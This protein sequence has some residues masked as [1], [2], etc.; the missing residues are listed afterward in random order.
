MGGDSG[1]GSV[2][3]SVVVG[4]GSSVQWMVCCRGS[5]ADQGWLRRS[6]TPG[7]SNARHCPCT[8]TNTG[9]STSGTDI[10]DS[11]GYV[12]GR[13]QGTITSSRGF[14][15]IG[16]QA[17]YG[18]YVS[19]PIKITPASLDS[20]QLQILAVFTWDS[21]D[22]TSPKPC[23]G[24]SAYCRTCPPSTTPPRPFP[25]KSTTREIVPQL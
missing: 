20:F 17:G 15:F 21:Q 10:R 14:R 16:I 6:P 1:S 25:H 18:N 22:C 23:V 24:V 19:G 2:I 7:C 8:S 3:G 12:L 9:T 13:I 4:P 5:L 11:L